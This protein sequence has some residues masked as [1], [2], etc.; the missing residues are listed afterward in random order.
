MVERIKTLCEKQNTTIKALE[1]E[2][3]ISNGSIR[4]W[5]TSKPS[6]ERVRQVAEKFN[7]SIDWLITGKEGKDLTPEEQK[8][9]DY[10]RKADER[11]KRNIIRTAEQESQELEYTTSKI[12]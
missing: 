4:N 3:N 9:I 8:L 2:I 5:D 1:R 11:G 7:V 10:Y 12:G 6:V